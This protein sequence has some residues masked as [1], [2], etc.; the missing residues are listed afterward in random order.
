MKKKTL[1]WQA[2]WNAHSWISDAASVSK[3][4]EQHPTS[5]TE[6]AQVSSAHCQWILIWIPEK[7]IYIQT[8]SS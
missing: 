6:W 7:C 8:N 2:T 4:I 1:P 3:G 5:T